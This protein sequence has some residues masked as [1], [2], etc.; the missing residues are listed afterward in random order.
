MKTIDDI[1]PQWKKVLMSHDNPPTFGKAVGYGSCHI[2]IVFHATT[3]IIPSSKC[4][5]SRLYMQSYNHNL[6]CMWEFTKQTHIS[7]TMTK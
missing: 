2:L 1:T 6:K 7:S 5:Y 4:Y 3:M